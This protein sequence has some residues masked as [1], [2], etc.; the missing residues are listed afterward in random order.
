M[1]KHVSRLYITYSNHLYSPVM[2]GFG[3][4]PAARREE[5]MREDKNRLTDLG[6]ERLRDFHIWV[7]AEASI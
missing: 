4:E 2:N 7:V 1:K 3:A 6:S 5:E